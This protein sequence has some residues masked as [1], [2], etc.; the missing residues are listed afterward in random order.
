VVADLLELGLRPPALAAFSL[1]IS[2]ASSALSTAISSILSATAL[3]T[4]CAA[5]VA[6]TFFPALTT[7]LVTPFRFGISPSSQWIEPTS[8]ASLSQS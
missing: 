2:A 7:V 8:F 1:T 6:S 5:S 3:T 4:P